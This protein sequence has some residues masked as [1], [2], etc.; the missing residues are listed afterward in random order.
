[1][2]NYNCTSIKIC[3]QEAKNALYNIF[4][5]KYC[6]IKDLVIVFNR[7]SAN[8]IKTLQFKENTGKNGDAKNGRQSEIL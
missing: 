4:L 5:I 8:G 7:T 1:M 6:I 3:Q 2:N